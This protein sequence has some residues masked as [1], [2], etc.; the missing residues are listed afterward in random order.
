VRGP[1]LRPGLSSR[2][3]GPMPLGIAFVWS[4]RGERLAGYFVVLAIFV[5]ACV[6]LAE[7]IRRLIHPE[8]LTH[9]WVLAEAGVVGFLG[10]EIAA[11]VRL[12]GGRRLGRPAL[13]ADGNDARVDGFGLAGGHRKC[14]HRRARRSHR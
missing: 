12:R 4:A 6:A 2:F 7:T 10:S 3:P 1:G 11:Q 14:R 9:L 13:I 8:H 5:S